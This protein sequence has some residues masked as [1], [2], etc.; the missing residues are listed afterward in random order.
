MRIVVAAVGRL[1]QGSETELS[2]RYRKR[3]AQ[4]G[5][6]LGLRDIEIK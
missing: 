5:R 2:E 4:T 1:K 3:V 6:Q